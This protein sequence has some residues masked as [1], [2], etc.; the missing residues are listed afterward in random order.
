MSKVSWDPPVG[1]IDGFIPQFVYSDV[2]LGIDWNWWDERFKTKLKF[3]L[4]MY[5]ER[6]DSD[7][8]CYK[9]NE[10]EREMGDRYLCEFVLDNRIYT[11][12]YIG[13]EV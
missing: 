2:D 6:A 1:P 10:F 9:H 13:E 11:F 7:D 3:P 5:D 8:W 4:A 12:I